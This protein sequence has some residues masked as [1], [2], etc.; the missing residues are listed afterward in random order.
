M[1]DNRNKKL[2]EII[3]VKEKV[4]NKPTEI[5]NKPSTS[6]KRDIPVYKR[7]S[8]EAVTRQSLDGNK[9]NKRTKRYTLQTIKYQVKV[10]NIRVMKKQSRPHQI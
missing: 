10:R 8:D 5:S 9:R 7:P 6:Q 1:Q 2:I 4:K 3:K